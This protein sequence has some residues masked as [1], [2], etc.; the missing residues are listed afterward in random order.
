MNTINNDDICLI[1]QGPPFSKKQLLIDVKNYSLILKNIVISSYSNLIDDE[2]NNYAKIINNDKIGNILISNNQVPN[3]NN[4]VDIR[5]DDDDLVEGFNIN[6]DWIRLLT[7]KRGIK[8]ANEYFIESKYYFILRADMT[9][10]NFEYIINKWKNLDRKI[11]DNIFFKEKIIFKYLNEHEK[12][13]NITDYLL[14]GNKT[15]IINFSSYNKKPIVKTGAPER[16]NMRGY[17]NIIDPTITDE[18]VY[19]SFMIHEKELDINWYKYNL[20]GIWGLINTNQILN[21]PKNNNRKILLHL[22][23]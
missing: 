1:L 23:K 14:F 22:R 8:C 7:I 11:I 10:N 20:F 16:V 5:Y 19:T 6:N 21:N 9:I 18:Y 4:Y 3:T 15:D 2:L 12:I 13:H 17:I